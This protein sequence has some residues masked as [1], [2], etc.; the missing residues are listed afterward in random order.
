MTETFARSR[1]RLVCR[2]VSWVAGAAALVL[3]FFGFQAVRPGPS[4]QVRADGVAPDFDL[5]TTEGRRMTL[6]ELRGRPVVLNFW[7]VWCPPCRVELPSFAELSR[8][9]PEVAVLGLAVDSGSAPELEAARRRLDIP[10][11][12]LLADQEVIDAYGASALPT[13]VVLDRDGRIV[14]SWTGIV[15]AWQLSAALA[16]VEDPKQPR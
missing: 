9:H 16:A 11:P 5:T 15:F 2:L 7:A 1:P 13:T 12:V 6:A 10:Y 4:V 8:T 14:A 3:G